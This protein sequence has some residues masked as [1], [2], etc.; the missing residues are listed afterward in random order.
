M[1]YVRDETR[2]EDQIDRPL[3][4]R[5]ISEVNVAALGIVRLGLHRP[6][7][8]ERALAARGRRKRDVDLTLNIPVDGTFT[9][10]FAHPTFLASH[11]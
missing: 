9:G 5:L 3:A 8:R 11:G 1:L 4:K 2:N 7:S 6:A 10:R